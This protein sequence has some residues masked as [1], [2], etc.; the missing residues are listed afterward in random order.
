MVLETTPH[1]AWARAELADLL[2]LK[3]D[4]AGREA[5]LAVLFGPET[6]RG[7]RLRWAVPE[8]WFEF[9]LGR[10]HAAQGLL[11]RCESDGVSDA[12]TGPM[13]PEAILCADARL[14]MALLLGD[15]AVARSARSALASWVTRPEVPPEMSRRFGAGLVHADGRIALLEGDVARATA[16]R[17]DLVD[18][19]P[20][21]VR[22]QTGE[23][24]TLDLNWRAR[25]AE[26]WIARTLFSERRSQGC[27]WELGYGRAALADGQTE[28]GVRVVQ[29]VASGRTCP[30]GPFVHWYFRAE[31][32]VLAAEAGDPTA[33]EAFRS[34]WPEVD[35]DHPLAIRAAR[36]AP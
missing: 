22:W 23:E 32:R 24:A 18:A 31:A 21:F 4:R 35:P 5:H 8:A 16:L 11:E 15:A 26:P 17:Q 14:D 20:A 30:E 7:E 34:A 10:W 33:I 27:A 19:A 28:E 3:G 6:E 2:G 29:D 1:D 12:E 9:G 36:G 13:L 25:P